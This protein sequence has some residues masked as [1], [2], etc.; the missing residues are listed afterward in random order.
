MALKKKHRYKSVAIYQGTEA[1][2]WDRGK[3]LPEIEIKIK[4]PLTIGTYVG[5]HLGTAGETEVPRM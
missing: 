5:R 2:F 3:T 1:Q 4:N